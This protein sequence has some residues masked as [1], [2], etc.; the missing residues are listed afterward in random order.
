MFDFLQTSSDTNVNHC[1]YFTDYCSAFVGIYD[2]QS[3]AAL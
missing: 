1:L 3:N 2:V